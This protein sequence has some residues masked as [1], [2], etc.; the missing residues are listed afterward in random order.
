[1]T[2]DTKFQYELAFSRNIGWVTHDEQAALRG[3]R[4]AIAGLGGVGGFH[5][6]ALARLGVGRFNLAE[7]DYFELPNF[8]RQ[9]G[10]T[11]STIGRN[12][13][14]VMLDQAL[15]INPEIEIRRF[16]RGLDAAG[17]DDFLRDVDIYVDGLDFFAFDA[18]AL[19]FRAC[20]A[21]GIPAV[22]V[23]PLGMGAA[24]LNFMP[25]GMSFDDYF[26]WGDGDESEKALR[27]LL[28]LAPTRLQMR[29]L[30]DRS[31]MN[32]A[33]KRGPS[34]IMACHLCAGVAATQVLKIL[35]RRGDVLAA[36]RGWHIDAYTHQAVRTWRPGGNANPL[37]RLLLAVARRILKGRK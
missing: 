12:K 27:F 13:L 4:V 32:L 34:T 7:F 24:L 3:K 8:N 25:G 11:L 9:A 23:A 28:G 30:V 35:L 15:D 5:L 16:D 37:Q 6:L 21:K 22:T 10:A 2:S 20:A 17:I 31:A 26:R 18:R 36:P 29:Y 14:D 33:E 1:M 19:V